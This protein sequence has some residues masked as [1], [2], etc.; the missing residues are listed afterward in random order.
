MQFRVTFPSA[1]EDWS[2]PINTAQWPVYVAT[3]DIFAAHLGGGGC[4]SSGRWGAEGTLGLLGMG[5]EAGLRCVETG[6]DVWELKLLEPLCLWCEVRMGL[7]PA[8]RGEG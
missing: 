6:A 8:R 7:S 1:P 3:P 5:R 2:C 4:P